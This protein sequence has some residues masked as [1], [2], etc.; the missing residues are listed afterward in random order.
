[1]RATTAA[2]SR[3]A[4]RRRWLLAGLAGAFA[5]SAL[6]VS[7]APATYALDPVHTRV[8]FAVEHAG[9]SKAIG[10]VSG[11]TGSLSFDPDDWTGARLEAQVPIARFDLGDEKWN[12]A[13][14]A[15]NL[16]DTGDHPVA[17]FTSTRVEPIDATHA[18]VF[19]TLTLRGVAQEVKLDVTLNALKR[20]PMPPFR[21]TVGFSATTTISRKAFG[22]TA[23]PTV[24]GDQVELRIE[25][26]ATRARANGDA[27]DEASQTQAIPG[28]T[29]APQPTETDA[30][31]PTEAPEPTDIPA[32]PDAPE[33]ERA[34]EPEPEPE[35]TP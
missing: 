6:D 8:M 35:P 4:A 16:L 2:D 7:A 13:A 10:T 18:S 1:M 17:T 33:P 24:I 27:Q 12:K 31:E 5:L 9:F 19:G 3:R 28:P 14:A 34:P 25:A 15:R 29:D 26:E 20:H 21:R 30:A 23:W 11:S 32:V 22:M